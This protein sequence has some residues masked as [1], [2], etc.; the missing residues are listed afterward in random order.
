MW[1]VD[2][3]E[4]IIG[5]WLA[6]YFSSRRR[7]TSC[8]LVTGVQTCALPIL[9]FMY[10]VLP[11]SNKSRGGSLILL[12]SRTCSDN[13]LIKVRIKSVLVRSLLSESVKRNLGASSLSLTTKQLIQCLFSLM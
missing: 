6:F 5:F 4:V 7:H 1:I 12:I 8:A 2:Y 13:K 11:L 9:P 3:K 10:V